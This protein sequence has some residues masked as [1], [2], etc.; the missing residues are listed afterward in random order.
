MVK[1]RKAT[2]SEADLN[3]IVHV[4]RKEEN[5]PWNNIKDCTLWTSKRLECGFYI[6]VTELDGEIIA[7]TEWVISDEFDKKILYL[8]YLQVDPDHQR[9]GVGRIII[10]DGIEYAKENKCSQITTNPEVEDGADIFYRKCGFKDGRKVFSL[11]VLTEPYKDYKFQKKI[12]EKVPFSAVKKR[13][14]IFG[15]WEFASHHVW[16]VFNESA[17]GRK[18]HV[19]SLQ[20]GTY[21]QIDDGSDGGAVMI[22]ANSKNYGD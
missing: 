13:K 17:H 20:D 8:G 12:L 11:Q 5:V 22:W 14:L 6:T 15:K 10:A 1:I 9:K 16:Q 21:I 4:H 3:G 19:I 18:S 7:Y 2:A